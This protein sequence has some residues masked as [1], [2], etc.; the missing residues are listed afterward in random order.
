MITFENSILINASQKA[1][2]NFA[3]DP[4]NID[5][6]QDC[7][8]YAEWTSEKTFSKGSTQYSISRLLDRVYVTLS[9]ITLWDSPNRFI[10]KVIKPYLIETEMLFEAI[11]NS[12]RVN[13]N[14]K[15]EPGDF[16]GL[17]EKEFAKY[18]AIMCDSEMKSLKIALEAQN[19]RSSKTV[20]H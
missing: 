2:F 9:E 6:W 20:Y 10:S 12:T 16:F 18:M 11:G 14:G 15:A 1:I 7:I 8:Q 5:K 3:S 4:A 13:L 19:G 17:P